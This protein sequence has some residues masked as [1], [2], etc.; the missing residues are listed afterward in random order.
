MVTKFPVYD[1]KMTS[2]EFRIRCCKVVAP[3][4]KGQDSHW[5]EAPWFIDSVGTL[6]PSLEAV[7]KMCTP[8]LGPFESLSFF[9]KQFLGNDHKSWR[10]TRVEDLHDNDLQLNVYYL[11]GCV[12]AFSGL[13]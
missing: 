12:E 2:H 6:P 5:M 13:P 8:S 10:P 4:N 3:K 7:P 11:K 9:E 1:L